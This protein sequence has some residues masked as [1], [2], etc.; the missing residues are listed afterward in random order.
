MK[1]MRIEMLLPSAYRFKKNIKPWLLVKFVS[2]S[3]KDQADFTDGY[4]INSIEYILYL[5]AYD[6][7]Y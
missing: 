6:Y 2:T 1:L 7:Q 4:I 3:I 5:I